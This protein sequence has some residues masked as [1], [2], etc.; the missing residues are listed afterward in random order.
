MA[1]ESAGVDAQALFHQ[2]RDVDRLGHAAD[3]CVPLLHRH[4]LFDVLNVL[5]ERLELLQRL[6]PVG[7]QV[8]G[9]LGKVDGQVS[10]AFIM[11]DE[12]AEV[13]VVLLQ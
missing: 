8:L 6:F 1:L 2:T 11:L 12:C 5:L 10:A 9:Q 13:A 4:D 7:I 3:L